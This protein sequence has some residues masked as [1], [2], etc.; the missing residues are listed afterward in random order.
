MILGNSRLL[1]AGSAGLSHPTAEQ[2]PTQ[3]RRCPQL[4]RFAD[5][6]ERSECPA[7]SRDMTLLPWRFVARARA[8]KNLRTASHDRLSSEGHLRLVRSFLEACPLDGPGIHC[9]QPKLTSAR[10]HLQNATHLP[11]HPRSNPCAHKPRLHPKAS[12]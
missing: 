1:P 9:R 10:R 4:C 2:R 11:C 3:T 8:F 6:S 7:H 12:T 5:R